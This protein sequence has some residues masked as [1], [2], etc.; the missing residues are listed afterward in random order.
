MTPVMAQAYQPMWWP[1][2][3]S[4]FTI[5]VFSQSRVLLATFLSLPPPPPQQVEEP[6]PPRMTSAA[7]APAKKPYRKAP[8]EHRELRLE[9]PG[10]RLEQEVSKTGTPA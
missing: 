3:M 7:P 10:S 5:F 9:I 4:P 2:H 1:Q 8:P 6:S